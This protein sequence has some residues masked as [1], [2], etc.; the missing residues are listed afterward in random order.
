MA[1]LGEGVSLAGHLRDLV[2]NHLTIMESKLIENK[3]IVRLFTPRFLG[4]SRSEARSLLAGLDKFERVVFDFE[5][6]TDVGQAFADE[7]YRVFQNKHP[8]IVIQE[9]NMSEGVKF[10]VERAKGEA[11][12]SLYV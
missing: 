3:I 1:G 12:R 7:I 11:K 6:I 8:D 2:D 4:V 10:M 5:H 9:E